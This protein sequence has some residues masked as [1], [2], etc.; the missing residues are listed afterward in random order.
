MSFIRLDN[1]QV[2][3]EIYVQNPWPIKKEELLSSIH[4]I[5]RTNHGIRSVLTSN[6]DAMQNAVLTSNRDAM[7]N[8]SEKDEFYRHL[9]KVLVDEIANELFKTEEEM[10][11]AASII[12]D[13]DM[14][15]MKSD[16]R[17]NAT[18][19]SRYEQNL[20]SISNDEL[21]ESLM[22]HCMNI[23]HMR[24]GFTK[25]DLDDMNA[26][27]SW[28]TAVYV[29]QGVHIWAKKHFMCRISLIESLRHHEMVKYCDEEMDECKSDLYRASDLQF[30]V[31]EAWVFD[32]SIT[33]MTQFLTLFEYFNYPIG[34]W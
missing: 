18:F 12:M 17:L 29:L 32:D 26:I 7:Q 2:A 25:K 11:N 24:A 28:I 27:D 33:D 10:T 8:D 4:S 14:Q 20:S 22:A 9:R 13:D 5:L 16:R 21:K 15:S 6:R 19:K 34:A 30:G 23:A 3:Y 31:P 1:K